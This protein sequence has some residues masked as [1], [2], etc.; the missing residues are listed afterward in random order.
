MFSHADSFNQDIG[1]WK[2]WFVSTMKSTFAHAKVFNQDISA[3]NTANVEN[4]DSM[5]ESAKAFNQDIGDWDIEDARWMRKMFS[6]SALN[7]ANYDS[8][9]NGWWANTSFLEHRVELDADAQYSSGMMSRKSQLMPAVQ[10][11]LSA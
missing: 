10:A 4:M 3:W 9:L 2:T 5:F 8:I 11:V 1:S 7:T 6:G